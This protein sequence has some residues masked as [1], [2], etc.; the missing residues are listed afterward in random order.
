MS[1]A[2]K[3]IRNLEAAGF[4]RAQAE[5]QELRITTRLGF[6]IISSSTILLSVLSWLIQT[7]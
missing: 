2:L 1:N 7:S 5:A 3:Y 4:A 6:A